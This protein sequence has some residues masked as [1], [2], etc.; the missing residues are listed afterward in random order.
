MHNKHTISYD[1]QLLR[2][3]CVWI[4]TVSSMKSDKVSKKEQNGNIQQN[5]HLTTQVKTVLPMTTMEDDSIVE[6]NGTTVVDI[7]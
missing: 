5:G 4:F 6:E 7:A 3:L 2:K 1:L